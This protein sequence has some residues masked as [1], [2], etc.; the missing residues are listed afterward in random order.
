MHPSQ[1]NFFISPVDFLP[2][3]QQGHWTFDQPARASLDLDGDRHAGRQIDHLVLDLHLAS[4]ARYP[5]GIEK[6]LPFGF[7]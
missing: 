2:T 5:R 7:A 1:K 6:L 4:F 3:A